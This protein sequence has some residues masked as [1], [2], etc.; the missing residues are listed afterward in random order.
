MVG[1]NPVNRI[2][3]LGLTDVD[4]EVLRHAL[5]YAALGRMIIPTGIPGMRAP[6]L[7]IDSSR[8]KVETSPG[9]GGPGVLG[10][11]QEKAKE[12]CSC[13]NSAEMKKVTV[14]VETPHKWSIGRA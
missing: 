5:L 3:V 6:A 11:I 4:N 14:T 10:K 12:L 1:N 8:W 7:T 13:A 2:D 9:A